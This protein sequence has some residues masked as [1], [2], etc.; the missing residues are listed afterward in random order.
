MDIEAVLELPVRLAGVSLPSHSEPDLY[1]P[2]V[3]WLLLEWQASRLGDYLD[4]P[5][6]VRI[7]GGEP[8]I[9]V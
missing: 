9:P 2:G 8:D 7:V 6:R 4:D 1:P 5:S 3:R